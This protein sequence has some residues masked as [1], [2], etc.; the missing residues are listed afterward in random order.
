MGNPSDEIFKLVPTVTV[1]A[2]S[3]TTSALRF[4]GT[5]ALKKITELSG[6]EREPGYSLSSVLPSSN[7][8]D[9]ARNRPED[10]ASVDWRQFRDHFRL[11]ARS[12]SADRAAVPYEL[13]GD[14]DIAS[15]Q[16]STDN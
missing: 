6:T 4:P 2:P 5:A 8:F 13:V 16:F 10:Q 14:R 1:N 12:R 11:S 3:L 9:F 7:Q 15:I